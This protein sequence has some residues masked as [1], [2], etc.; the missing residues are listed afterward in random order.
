MIVDDK[1]LA[2]VPPLKFT[3]PDDYPDSNPL[4]DMNMELCDTSQLFIDVKKRFAGNLKKLQNKYSMT[5]LLETWVSSA[6]INQQEQK[7][8]HHQYI[9]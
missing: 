2:S 3:L 9:V 8:N 6:Y 7:S 1:K 5:A 4:C